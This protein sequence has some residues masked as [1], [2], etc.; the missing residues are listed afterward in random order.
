VTFGD[1]L[2]FARTTSGDADERIRTEIE[3]AVRSLI[4]NTA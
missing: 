3:A 1:A 2:T 4:G